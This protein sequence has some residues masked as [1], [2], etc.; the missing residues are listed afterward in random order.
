LRRQQAVERIAV[1]AARDPHVGEALQT[2]R[3]QPGDRE[4]VDTVGLCLLEPTLV[5]V[6]LSQRVL[7]GDLDERPGSNERA[8][9]GFDRL[10]G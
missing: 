9:S 2:A 6:E 10:T 1:L 4:H 5:G 7:D 8:L 3:V